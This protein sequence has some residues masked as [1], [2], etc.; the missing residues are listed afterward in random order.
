V[1]NTARGVEPVEARLVEGIR[2]ALSRCV[3]FGSAE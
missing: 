2:V 3:V 1:T